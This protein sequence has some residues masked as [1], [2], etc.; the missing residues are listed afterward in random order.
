MES[1]LSLMTVFYLPFLFKEPMAKTMSHS[2]VLQ[3]DK[4]I[5]ILLQDKILSI[6]IA[7]GSTDISLRETRKN[8]EMKKPNMYITWSCFIAQLVE[9]LPS[10][11]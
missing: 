10:M 11:H 5:N 7:N 4:Y 2:E 6:M 1:E 9:L 8:L 3:G